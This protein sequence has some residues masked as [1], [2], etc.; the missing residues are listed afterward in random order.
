VADR[1]RLDEFGIIATYFRPLA[2]GYSGA[3]DLTDDAAL[4]EPAAGQVMVATTDTLVAGVHYLVGE[5]P[6]VVA[7]RLLRVNLSDLAAMGAKPTAYLLSL[8][9]PE[10]VDE[11]WFES[12]CEGLRAD[13]AAF[14]ISLAGGNM[15]ATPGPAVLTV[16]AFGETPKGQALLRSGAKPGDAVM[17]SGT[18]GDG[19]LGLRA[20]QGTLAGVGAESRAFLASRYRRPEPRLALGMA[21]RGIARSAIDIS[22][23]LVADLGHI[24]ETSGVAAEI[25]WPSVP[26]SDAARQALAADP[27]LRAA[28]LGGGDDYELLVSVPEIA[29]AAAAAAADS[30]N[31]AL[32]R[33]GRIE[34]G[35]GVRVLD[36]QGREIPVAVSGYQ[37]F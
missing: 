25:D 33:I 27:A 19:A 32:T 29:L 11:S 10:D 5:A 6:D 14:G 2:K 18:V 34:R 16:T 20:L 24:C 9:L 37:H 28:V 21:L 17:V 23:G 26:L 22:D 7:R 35:K 31:V 30:C 13:Q 8:T 15:A 3:L 1:R 12:F 4:I 36:G